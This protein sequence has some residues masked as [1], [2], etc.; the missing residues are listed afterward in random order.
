[1]YP[2]YKFIPHILNKPNIFGYSQKY[3]YPSIQIQS[4]HYDQLTYS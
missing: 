1:M 3:R 4:I 2:F